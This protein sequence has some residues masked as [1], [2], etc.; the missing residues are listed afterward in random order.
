MPD[1]FEIPAHRLPPGFAERIDAPPGKPAETRPAATAV[2]LRDADLGPETLLLRRPRASGFVPGAYVF[3]GGRVDEADAE[4]GL[5]GR[6]V[7]MPAAPEPPAPYWIAAAREV[8]EETGVLLATDGVGRPAPDA[9]SDRRM[10]D[11]RESLLAEE[12]VLLDVLAEGSLALDFSRTVYCAHWITP[13]A[14]PR[15]YD[16]RFFLAALPAG[17]EATHDP[18]EMTDAL[19]LAPAAAL[20]RFAA[21]RLPMVFPTVKMLERLAGF[22]SV[23]EALEA[24]RGRRVR[25]VLP[26]LVRTGSGVAIVVEDESSGERPE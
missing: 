19:W 22:H 4:P 9:A 16:T 8:F 5:L 3:P 21:G 7:G 24:F 2:L 20:E 13:L 18:R 11:W 12:A 6:V 1:P 26:R 10:G 23:A 14:E 17:R 15:R 25:A